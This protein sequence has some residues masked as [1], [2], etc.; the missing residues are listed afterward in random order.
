MLGD[1]I[2]GLFAGCALRVCGFWAEARR[3]RALRR[4]K[5]AYSFESM[6][7]IGAGRDRFPPLDNLKSGRVDKWLSRQAHNL[8]SAGSN[9][10]PAPTS[11]V[12]RVYDWPLPPKE[13][14]S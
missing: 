2:A 4:M 5:V 11:K 7:R 1:W 3:R 12:R 6:R 8:E 9:P 10:A 13:G 14:R